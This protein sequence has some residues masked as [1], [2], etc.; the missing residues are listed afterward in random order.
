M[1]QRLVCSVPDLGQIPRV[2]LN[3][4][5]RRINRRRFKL[6]SVAFRKRI[7]LGKIAV[8]LLGNENMPENQ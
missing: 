1:C 8:V 3:E 7:Q 2:D 4:G 5:L 6:L